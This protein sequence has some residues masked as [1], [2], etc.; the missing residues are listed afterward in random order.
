LKPSA[1]N[2]ATQGVAIKLINRRSA[3]AGDAVETWIR[4]CCQTTA[5]GV[6]ERRNAGTGKLQKA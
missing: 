2:H 1:R 6:I 4:V 5:Q 3:H